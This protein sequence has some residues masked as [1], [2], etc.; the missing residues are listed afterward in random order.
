[1]DGI[2]STS[3]PSTCRSGNSNTAAFELRY[4]ALTYLYLANLEKVGVRAQASKGTPVHRSL[5]HLHTFNPPRRKP[6]GS[7]TCH[8]VQAIAQHQSKMQAYSISPLESLRIR[9][10]RPG[11]STRY[12]LAVAGS[13]EFPLMLA[14]PQ[15]PKPW[16][17][18]SKEEG[19]IA[20]PCPTVE[21][22]QKKKRGASRRWLGICTEH[23]RPR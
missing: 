20:P 10:R 9:W 13:A 16:Q 11:C 14:I 3:M 1:M 12:R 2:G 5:A 15:S 21:R 23:Y 8:S 19:E 18:K 22:K 4:S 17:R 6:D 7:T